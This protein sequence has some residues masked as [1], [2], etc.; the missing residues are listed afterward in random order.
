MLNWIEFFNKTQ[1]YDSVLNGKKM[2]IVN[3]RE[4]T[5][6]LEQLKNITDVTLLNASK[7][8]DEIYEINGQEEIMKLQFNEYHKQALQDLKDIGKSIDAGD[9]SLLE[10]ES[11]IIMKI[12]TIERKI[13]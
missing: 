2:K 9:I 1:D 13:F 11:E 8:D 4:I 12:N 6:Q 5:E 10:L 7:L 3:R